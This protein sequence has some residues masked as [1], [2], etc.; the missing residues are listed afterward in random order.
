MFVLMKLQLATYLIPASEFKTTQIN[1]SS[2]G[3]LG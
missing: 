1:I 2:L 3:K